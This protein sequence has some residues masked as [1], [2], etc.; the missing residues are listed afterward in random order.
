MEVFVLY[1]SRCDSH[2]SESCFLSQSLESNSS[3]IPV[4]I[5]SER[6][7]ERERERDVVGKSCFR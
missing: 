3:F 6:E 5:C 1:I 4:L 7:R 2:D